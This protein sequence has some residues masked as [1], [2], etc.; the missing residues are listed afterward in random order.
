MLKIILEKSVIGTAKYNDITIEQ[1]MTYNYETK[2]FEKYKYDLIDL[3]AANADV[4][5][6]FSIIDWY[7]NTYTHTPGETIDV[8]FTPRQ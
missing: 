6:T 1:E 3:Y 4:T 2:K 8:K 5:F 7:G